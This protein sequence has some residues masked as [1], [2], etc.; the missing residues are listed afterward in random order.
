MGLLEKLRAM[1]DDPDIDADDPTDPAGDPAESAADDPAETPE[2]V[3]LGEDP[4]TEP[5]AAG[6]DPA[7]DDPADDPAGE[8]IPDGDENPDT[9]RDSLNRLAAEN[10]S[11]RSENDMLRSRVAELGGD[12][13]LG[14]MEADPEPIV[15]DEDDEYDPDADVADQEDQIKKLRG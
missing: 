12:A 10:E 7:G 14:I 11:L 2:A 6:S 15:E 1:L 13:A 9:L 5:D 4:S 3:G 8:T